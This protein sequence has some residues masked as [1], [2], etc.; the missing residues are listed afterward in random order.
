MIVS[1][2]LRYTGSLS[3]RYFGSTAGDGQ[4]SAESSDSTSSRFARVTSGQAQYEHSD[5]IEGERNTGLSACSVLRIEPKCITIFTGLND[6]S[7]MILDS[8]YKVPM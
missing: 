1:E 4:I 8:E 3:R 7:Y 5:L 6:H 2:D